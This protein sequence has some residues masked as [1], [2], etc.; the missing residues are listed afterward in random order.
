MMLESSDGLN[1][2]VNRILSFD[3]TPLIQLK[4]DLLFHFTLKK[5]GIVL[6]RFQQDF[7]QNR[8]HYF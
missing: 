2:K 5:Y 3:K 6:G 1:Q 4:I 8:L 7:I